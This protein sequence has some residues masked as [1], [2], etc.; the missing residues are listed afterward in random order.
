VKVAAVVHFPDIEVDDDLRPS[1]SNVGALLALA[2]KKVGVPDTHGTFAD[3]RTVDPGEALSEKWAD[4]LAAVARWEQP[5]YAEIIQLP[6]E[7]NPGRL[8]R[9]KPT[10]GFHQDEINAVGQLVL[11]DGRARGITTASFNIRE[12]RLR[13]DHTL[14]GKWNDHDANARRLGLVSAAWGKRWGGPTVE[15]VLATTA[16]AR[17]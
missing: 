16:G 2:A 11:T 4:L 15:E 1:R 10:L 3:V 5:R 9:W 12:A 7:D 8:W 14:G 13:L 17:A 6:C